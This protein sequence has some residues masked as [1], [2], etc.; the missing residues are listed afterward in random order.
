MIIEIENTSSPGASFTPNTNSV[1]LKIYEWINENKGETLPF[2]TFRR[3]L[4]REKGVNDN[5][6]RNIF[7]LLKNCEMV[8]Y[9]PGRD[10]QVDFFYTKR[11]LA[12]V[13]TLE[14]IEMVKAGNFTETQKTISI[15]K[16]EKIKRALIYEAL[17]VVI[18]KPD[19]NYTEPFSDLI[20]FL[21]KY[22]KISK[23][24]Y[25]YMLYVRQNMDIMQTLNTIEDN[26]A[27]YRNGDL[28]FET[29]VKVSNDLELREKIKSKKRKEGLSYLTSYGYFTSLLQQAGLITKDG[30]YQLI[31]NDKRNLLEQLGGIER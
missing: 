5:N 21:I 30:N 15:N 16:F 17:L 12:Y 11:G 27:S 19:V 8:N 4:E 28:T 9:E 14:S 20:R 6:N 10:L 7:P 2:V 25:A 29:V 24:E 18:K 1:L 31:V 23:Q 22:N 3:R 26:I 13:K